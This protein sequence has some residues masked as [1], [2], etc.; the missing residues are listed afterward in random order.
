MAI[1]FTPD[2]K[3][4]FSSGYEKIVKQWDIKTG[5]C[6]EYLASDRPTLTSNCFS[7]IPFVQ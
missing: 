5:I 1:A 6:S 2:G 3:T 4:L 7:F